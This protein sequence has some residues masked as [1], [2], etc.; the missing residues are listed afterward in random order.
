MG[1][2]KTAR[3][4]GSRP[5]PTEICGGYS[6]HDSFGASTNGEMA[7]QSGRGEERERE[8]ERESPGGGW[9]SWDWYHFW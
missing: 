9:A 3:A 5:G 7:R 6:T 1:S 2:T 8:R 4:P